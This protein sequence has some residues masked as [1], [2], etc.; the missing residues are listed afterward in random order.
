MVGYSN[1]LVAQ[2]DFT[3]K[4]VL[5]TYWL[6]KSEVLSL[7]AQ[8]SLLASGGADCS[9]ILYDLLSAKALKKLKGQH[10]NSVFS[11]FFISPGRLL[12]VG[13]DNLVKVRRVFIHSLALEY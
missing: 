12:S 10:S 11:L 9:I 6:H 2:F 1:G 4:E 5:N 7:A 3:S 13:K 8:G